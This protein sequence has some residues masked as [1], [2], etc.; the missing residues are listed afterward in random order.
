MESWAGVRTAA[1]CLRTQARAGRADRAGARTGRGWVRRVRRQVGPSSGPRA[2]CQLV[3]RRSS[4]EIVTAAT[5]S[6]TVATV[7]PMFTAERD[8]DHEVLQ[9]VDV[10]VVTGRACAASARSTSRTIQTKKLMTATVAPPRPGSPR[11]RST[12]AHQPYSSAADPDPTWPRPV[13]S[14]A[15]WPGRRP[16]R[17]A[18]DTRTGRSGRSSC[19][20]PSPARAGAA[21]AG[22]VPGLVRRRERRPQDLGVLP[23]LPEPDQERDPGRRRT[24]SRP[25]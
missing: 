14:A 1:D 22:G 19:R 18:A 25:D 8:P 12:R 11:S 21:A 13:A 16:G 4:R 5:I 10:D 7:K 24:G 15:R 17:P 20:S 3:T 2:S 6:S 9:V 23:R